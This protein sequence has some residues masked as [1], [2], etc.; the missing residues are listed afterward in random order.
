MPIE[1]RLNL[2][3]QVLEV[4]ET[5]RRRSY[6]GPVVLQMRLATTDRTPAHVHTIAKNILD[7]LG[8]P[9]LELTTSRKGLL[10]FDDVQVH[11]LSVSCEHGAENPEIHIQVQS[12]EDFRDDLGLALHV[13]KQDGYKESDNADLEN[14]FRPFGDLLADWGFL[15]AQIGDEAFE[16]L[17][18]ITR[19]DAQRR[20]LGHAKL[21]PE[22]LAYFFR[23]S[24]L[25]YREHRIML[26]E[27]AKRWEDIFRSTP[28][29]ILIGELPQI[30]GSSVGY[31]AEIDK[32][33]RAFRSRQGRLLA[34]LRIPVALEVI[35]KP[36]PPT[37]NHALHDLDNVMRT[38][39]VPKVT[40]LLEP[41]SDIAWTYDRSVI[42]QHDGDHDIW[43]R[44]RLEKL[45]RSARVGLIR[46]EAWRIP[47][48]PDDTSPGFVSAA[49]VSDDFGYEDSISRIARLLDQW[50]ERVN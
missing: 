38:Y 30:P 10:Y 19:R 39:L 33:I 9:L 24:D 12:L 27:L 22:D 18:D 49:V 34:P 50:A 13:L 16:T 35:I 15:R 6:R 40:E 37:R 5:R 23:A 17:L 21:R 3:Q 45:P 42:A 20:L 26:D 4:L 47:R 8:R 31:R 29:R 7:L 46:Y 36:P 41:P 28:L 2:Q 1:D 25:S 44:N 48:A 14:E 11:A 32:H 43:L